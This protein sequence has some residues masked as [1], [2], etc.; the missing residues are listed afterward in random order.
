MPGENTPDLALSQLSV[1]ETLEPFAVFERAG[2]SF[3]LAVRAPNGLVH[4]CKLT[5]V[6]ERS[7]PS[8]QQLAALPRVTRILDWCVE[9]LRSQLIEHP[10]FLDN[11]SALEDPVVDFDYLDDLQ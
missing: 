9:L 6:P 10:I 2:R 7:V 3:S 4:L 11:L 8:A 5:L 1:V